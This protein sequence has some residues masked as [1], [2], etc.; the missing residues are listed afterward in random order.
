MK[1]AGAARRKQPQLR[2]DVRERRT[3]RKRVAAAQ[4]MVTRKRMQ[5]VTGKTV[6]KMMRKKTMIKMTMQMMM[7][8][9]MI[10]MK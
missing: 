8:K 1:G 5:R 9:V 2:W 3:M 4:G 6:M 10:E 7:T